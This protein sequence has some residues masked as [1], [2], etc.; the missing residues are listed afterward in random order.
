ME[1]NVDGTTTILN[2]NV[3]L[4]DWLH[5]K[6]H[7]ELRGDLESDGSITVYDSS[8]SYVSF[9]PVEAT[10]FAKYLANQGTVANLPKLD[11]FT[12]Y[13][14]TNAKADESDYLV[15]DISTGSLS[16]LHLVTFDNINIRLYPNHI[17]IYH[18]SGE[19][20]LPGMKNGWIWMTKKH[21][22]LTLEIYQ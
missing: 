15:D 1:K 5:F 4:N 6:G 19:L 22:N 13:N 3:T 12:L 20:E 9:D 2:G 14:D 18:S 17:G 21:L 16:L 8:G 7:I 11:R 10:G